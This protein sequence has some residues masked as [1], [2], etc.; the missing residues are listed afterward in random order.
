MKYGNL[1]IDDDP[2]VVKNRFTTL[3]SHLNQLHNVIVKY[4]KRTKNFTPA[5]TNNESLKITYE[6]IVA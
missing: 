5:E 1:K 4:E 2:Q 3:N 6:N